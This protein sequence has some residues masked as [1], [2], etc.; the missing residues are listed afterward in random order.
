M[1]RLARILEILFLLMML[2]LCG[3][4]ISAGTGRVPYIFG[5]RV[6]KVV[7][8]SMQPAISDSTCI[9]I[10]RENQEEIQVGDVI[11]FVSDDPAIQ[12]FL[13]THRVYE[14]TQDE[15]SGEVRYITKGDAM[16]EPDIW[17]VA[18]EDIQGVYVRE[19]P[20]GKEIFKMIAFFSDRTH[21]FV[22]VILPLLLCCLSYMKDLVFALLG[23][24]E[25][26]E[27]EP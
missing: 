1:K 3:V 11:T 20:F 13:N 5:Y 16:E 19:M 23:K 9:L 22:V 15:I 10:H 21:Y 14:I 12:G 17:P 2:G 27:D 24:E 4:V 25:E 18:Y 8:G 6:L 26:D 7:S